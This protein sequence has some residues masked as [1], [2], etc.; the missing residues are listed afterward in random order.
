[1]ETTNLKGLWKLGIDKYIKTYSH[2]ELNEMVIKSARKSIRNVYPGTIFRLVVIGVIVLIISLLLWGNRSKELMIVNIS[3]LV[4][5][6][7]AY[8]LWEL[9]AYKMRKYTYGMPVKDWLEYRI[10][11]IEKTMKF[12]TKYNLAIY[13]CSFIFAIGFYASYLLIMKVTPG[14]FSIVVVPVILIIYLCILRC[15]MNRN[16]KKTHHELDELYKQFDELNE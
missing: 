12:S 10:K 16:Y 1:M 8:Y 7:V 6:S 13:L 14:L 5:L 11:E 3:A 9:S 4:V 15:S 2:A